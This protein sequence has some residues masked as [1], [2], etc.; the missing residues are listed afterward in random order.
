MNRHHKKICL[1]AVLA[2]TALSATAQTGTTTP[3]TPPAAVGVT[4]QAAAEAN[5]NAVPRS[6]TGT[7]VRTGPSAEN[8][9]RAAM[10]GDGAR[11]T[12]G[13]TDSTGNRSARTMRRARADR[14]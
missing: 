10:N 3:A 5:R 12:T 6:D 2:L 1:S 8:R 9:A 11:T 14:N 13:S 7:V 4:P